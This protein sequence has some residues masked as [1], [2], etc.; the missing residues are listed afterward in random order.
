MESKS[1]KRKR[2][3]GRPAKHEAEKLVII[4]GKVPPEVRATIQL[5]AKAKY[6]TMSSAVRAACDLLI[7]QEAAKIN[8]TVN[9]N[10]LT[11]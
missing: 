5:I 8:S 1:R 4:G 2:R 9:E 10:V 11:G 3:V 6:W 7:A